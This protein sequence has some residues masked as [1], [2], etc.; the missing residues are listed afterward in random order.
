M[1]A[2]GLAVVLSAAAEADTPPASTAEAPMALRQVMTKLGQ[3]MQSVAGAI[4]RED[5]PQVAR[6]APEIAHHEA[7]PLTEKLRILA[8]MGTDAGRFKGFDEQTHHA[9]SAMGEAAARQD[10]RAVIESFARV[11]LGCLGCHE[12]FRQAF[13][14]HF[15]RQP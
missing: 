9:A 6:L 3:D 5:W 14:D 12:N 1:R 2:L 8:W 4:A 13:I 10:G 15:Y 7:P 11:P